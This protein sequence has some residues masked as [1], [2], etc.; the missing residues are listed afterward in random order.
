[1]LSQLLSLKIMASTWILPFEESSGFFKDV[2][3]SLER[4]GGR[5]CEG[6]E[7]AEGERIL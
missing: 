5:K 2:F 3:I 4:E 7:E 1:M 6:E